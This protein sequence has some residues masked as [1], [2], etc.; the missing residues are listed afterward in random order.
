M[1]RICILNQKGGVAKT[2]TAINLAAGL[3]IND[4]KVLL[5]DMDPQGQVGT[6][7]PQ[8]PLMNACPTSARISM[9]C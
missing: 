2:T 1:R 6:Y 5:L 9:C 7:F 4:K 3:A 8:K